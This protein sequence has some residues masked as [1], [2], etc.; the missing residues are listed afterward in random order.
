MMGHEQRVV[1]LHNEIR[2]NLEKNGQPA[3]A[4]MQKMVSCFPSTF[5]SK[6]SWSQ[7][8]RSCPRT[9]G[10]SSQLFI[11]ST[12]GLGYGFVCFFNL[13]C[14][15][16]NN[17]LLYSAVIIGVLQYWD[18]EIAQRAQTVAD[19]CVFKHSTDREIKGEWQ[20]W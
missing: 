19:T 15:G 12:K 14:T 20:R 8:P 2:R 18:N 7:M 6:Q 13:D 10:N 1:N 5:L 4:N 9:Y 16:F 3:A 11:F 17:T